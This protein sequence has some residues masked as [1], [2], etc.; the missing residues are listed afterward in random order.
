M[1]KDTPKKVVK[2]T[3]KSGLKKAEKDTD[4]AG[5]PVQ[6]KK[7][8]V[9]AVKAQTKPQPKKKAEPINWTERWQSVKDYFTASYNELKKVTWPG[10]TALV[11]YTGVVLVSVALVAALIWIFDSALSFVLEL[12][13]KAAA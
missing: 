6:E 1:A 4:K 2:A 7:T 5:K 13:F 11:A 12:L 9:V 3:P 8:K 10:R